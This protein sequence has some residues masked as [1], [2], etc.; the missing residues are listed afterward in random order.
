M[1]RMVR[2]AACC[3]VV[4]LFAV[5]APLAAS[6]HEHRDIADNQYTVTVG[7][8]DEPAFVGE[9]NGLDLRVEKNDLAATPDA[10]GEYPKTPVEGLDQTLTVEVIYGDQRMNLTLEPRFRDPGA[11]NAY[12]FP[13]AAGDYSFHITGQIE[14]VAIDETFTSSPETFSGVEDRA[15]LEFPKQTGAAG[16]AGAVGAVDAGGSGL[17]GG[18]GQGGL[19]AAG[20]V[21]LSLTGFWLAKRRTALAPARA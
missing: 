15:P 21:A 11:Y 8:L 7:F 5:L 3:V 1:H 9:K 13:M 12:F 10:D 20:V 2:L 16:S 18:F 17:G 4:A 19:I 14:G 6:A